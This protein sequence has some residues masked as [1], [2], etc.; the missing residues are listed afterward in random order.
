MVSPPPDFDRE[1]WR[2]FFMK[3][4]SKTPSAASENYQRTA[5]TMSMNPPPRPS[6]PNN[7][8]A[9]VAGR[10]LLRKYSQTSHQEIA[11]RPNEIL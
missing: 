6:H 7:I 9:S 3:R 2:G 1:R 10:V 11:A 8:E 4:G 5:R